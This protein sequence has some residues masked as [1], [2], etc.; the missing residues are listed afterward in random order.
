MGWLRRTL[1][2]P[3]PMNTL[4][5]H[6]HVE[7]VL[8]KTTWRLVERLFYNRGCKERSTQ[9]WLR[10]EERKSGQDLCSWEGTQKMDYMGTDPSWGM[11]NLSH[12]LY[13]PALWS[14]TRNISPLSW[15]ENKWDLTEGSK[16]PR[17]C[18]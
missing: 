16:K 10:K 17:L 3:S 7:E 1:S 2:S 12:I 13:I 15:F 14:D 6:L 18:S 11:R 9:N 8:L 5:I 4:K